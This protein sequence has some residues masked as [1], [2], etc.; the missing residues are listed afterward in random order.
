MTLPAVRL[1][2]RLERLM[3]HF[4]RAPEESIW[5]AWGSVHESKAAQGF[6]GKE[7]VS[8]EAIMA[9]QRAATMERLAGQRQVL[10]VQ[11]T[12]S[13]DDSHH[14]ATAGMG[15]LDNT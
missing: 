12:T 13:F 4:S 15:A 6:L 11:D 3:A 9:G 8:H 1:E 5:Q 10:L 14:R 7:R 2:G